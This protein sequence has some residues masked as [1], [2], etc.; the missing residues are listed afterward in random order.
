[1]TITTKFNPSQVVF[2]R[3]G[4]RPVGC[5]VTEV[6]ASSMD[7]GLD[8]GPCITK[9][10]YKLRPQDQYG[11]GLPP[12]IYKLENEVWKD[13]EDFIECMTKNTQNIIAKYKCQ[14]I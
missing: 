11:S 7:G 12:E 2:I 13:V 5:I 8:D 3:H 4:N 10:G 14:V 9:I 1:M 6:R